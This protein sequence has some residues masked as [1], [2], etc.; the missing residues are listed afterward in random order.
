MDSGL[1]IPE[2]DDVVDNFDPL[3]KLLPEE[4][5]GVMDQLFCFE[6]GGIMTNLI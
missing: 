3:Q 6:V 4:V 2:K 1:Y 5:V